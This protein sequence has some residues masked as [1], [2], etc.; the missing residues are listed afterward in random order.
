M[1]V[2]PFITPSESSCTRSESPSRAARRV[3]GAQRHP[4]GRHAARHALGHKQ[5][6]R[7]VAHN[8]RRSAAGE[9]RARSGAD[10]TSRG[11][12]AATVGRRRRDGTCR[13][14]SIELRSG[15]KYR[16]FTLACSD[17]E[18]I[19]EVP[20]I[21]AAFAR[22]LPKA[23][24]RVMSVD[25]LESGGGLASGEVDVAIAPAHGPLPDV[26]SS[27]LYEEEGVLVVRK[28]HP[29]VRGRMSKEQFNTLRHIDILLALGGPGI[30]HRIVEEF[31]ASHGSI[32]TSRFRYRALPRP[33]PSL[34]K[35][36][37]SPECPAAWRPRFFVRCRSSPWPC[38]FLRCGFGFN[39]CGTSALTRTR[40][41]SSFVH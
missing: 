29:H 14:E 1:I 15:T 35:P 37:G 26:H 27:E 2:I 24:L 28:G 23:S 25:Q 38:L 7:P 16:G 10:S 33:R 18:Q 5:R 19:S 12:R 9:E 3:D 30:G 17:A 13:R 4:R 32:A 20:R 8:L 22:K 31:F 36:I 39:W 41:Q 21:A 34:R 11:P 6:A 40:A